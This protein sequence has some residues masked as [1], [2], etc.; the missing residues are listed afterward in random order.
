M[1]STKRDVYPLTRLNNKHLQSN[2]FRS[3]RRINTKFAMVLSILLIVHALPGCY[4]LHPASTPNLKVPPNTSEQ[5]VKCEPNPTPNGTNF[6][7]DEVSH[8][9]DDW[10]AAFMLSTSDRKKALNNVEPPRSNQQ[11]WLRVFLL[12]NHEAS[13][14]ELKEAEH[15][16]Q[17]QLNSNHVE[18]REY[19]S[20]ELHDYILK[21]NLYFQKKKSEAVLLQRQLDARNHSIKT[22]ELVNEVLANKIEALT[23]IEQRM[24][25][26][27]NYV[28]SEVTP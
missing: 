18:S 16:L 8:A 10:I 3:V 4:S 9:N 17:N 25:L 19:V 1:K 5:F 26:R 7:T 15:L 13:Y 24:K 21:L 20:L 14:R 11:M 6:T 27:P 28:E 23:N 22:Q 12:T 2:T